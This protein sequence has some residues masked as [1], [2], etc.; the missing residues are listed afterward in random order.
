TLGWLT[1]AGWGV[2]CSL[3]REI[4]EVAR[5]IAPFERAVLRSKYGRELSR[6]RKALATARARNS[7]KDYSR[8]GSTVTS[9]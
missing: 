3:K 6:H 8:Y 2:V 5:R 1:S 7:I 9:T 4:D